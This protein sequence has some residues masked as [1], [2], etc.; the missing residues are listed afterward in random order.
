MDEKRTTYNANDFARYYA[1]EMSPA[2]MHAME[3]AALADSFV[4]DALEGYA[5]TDSP[6]SDTV[7]IKNRLTERSARQQKGRI[8]PFSIWKWWNVAAIVIVVAGIGFF[9]FRPGNHVANRSVTASEIKVNADTGATIFQG[10]TNDSLHQADDI[11]FENKS[12]EK[13]RNLEGRARLLEKMNAN[14]T[15]ENET[16]EVFKQNKTFDEA[17]TAQMNNAESLATSKSDSDNSQATLA[18]EGKI[19][20]ETGAPVPFAYV[21]LKNENKIV[22]SDHDG[23][24]KLS[25]ADSSTPIVAS[26]VGFNSKSATLRKMG[27]NDIILSRDSNQLQEVSVTALGKKRSQ[28]SKVPAVEGKSAGVG[29]SKHRVQPFPINKEFEEYVH[30]N[31]VP[32]SSLDNEELSGEVTLSFFVNRDGRP[33]NIDVIKSNCKECE[34]QAVQLLKNGP[35]WKKQ[36][37]KKGSVNIKF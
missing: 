1:G 27:S 8:I 15:T 29:I 9:V 33:E 21:S 12:P 14:V 23:N 2:E 11:A 6:E 19:M 32:V 24:F 4:A 30:K 18:F 7:E 37:N 20:D 35:A 34:P 26:A 31:N 10:L 3:K 28:N 25:S 17:A 22:T 13:K 36:R 16:K 5:H